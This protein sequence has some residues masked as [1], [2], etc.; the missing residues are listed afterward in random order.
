MGGGQGC[1]QGG[2][3]GKVFTLLCSALSFGQSYID[4]LDERRK[5]NY[6]VADIHDIKKKAT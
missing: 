2:R 1:G 4:S 3:R 6:E 5:D